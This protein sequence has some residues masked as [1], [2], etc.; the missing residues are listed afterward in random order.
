MLNFINDLLI[1]SNRQPIKKLT[2]FVNVPE[3][4]II[5]S[6]WCD[7]MKRRLKSLTDTFGPELYYG[8]VSINGQMNIITFLTSL[9]LNVNHELVREPQFVTDNITLYRRTVY[10]IKIRS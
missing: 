9:L 6:C 8:T 2:D 1:S 10:T 3:S 4:V 5:N 7:V